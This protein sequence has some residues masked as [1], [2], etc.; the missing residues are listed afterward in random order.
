MTNKKNIELNKTINTIKELKE[1]LNQFDED[2]EVVIQ[3]IDGEYDRVG[4]IDSYSDNHSNFIKEYYL[5]KEHHDALM[6][7]CYSEA[8]SSQY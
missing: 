7:I 8:I 6:L 4:F 3:M 2:R 5:P 1:F